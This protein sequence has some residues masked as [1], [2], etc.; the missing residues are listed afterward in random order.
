MSWKAKFKLLEGWFTDRPSFRT[1]REAVGYCLALA[2][3]KTVIADFDVVR[4][5]RPANSSFVPQS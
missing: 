4:R 3:R 5:K 1:R 2:N